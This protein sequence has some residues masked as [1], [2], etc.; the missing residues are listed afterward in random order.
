MDIVYIRLKSDVPDHQNAHR[1]FVKNTSDLSVPRSHTAAV[2]VIHLLLL[3]SNG[4]DWDY[5]ETEAI[6]L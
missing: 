3:S 5:F 4:F 2:S 1:I 6:I